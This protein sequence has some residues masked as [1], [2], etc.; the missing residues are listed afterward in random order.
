MTFA[1]SLRREL[2]SEEG[3]EFVEARIQSSI[4]GI[5]AGGTNWKLLNSD[6]VMGPMFIEFIMRRQLK[7]RTEEIKKDENSKANHKP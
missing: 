1:N 5:A 6:A 4:A 7:H 3:E 2:K